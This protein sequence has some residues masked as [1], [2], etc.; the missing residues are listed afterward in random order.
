MNNLKSLE[1]LEGGICIRLVASQIKAISS[2]AA[3]DNFCTWPQSQLY[4]LNFSLL[5]SLKKH[6]DYMQLARS[7]GLQCH[8]QLH[9]KPA[10]REVGNT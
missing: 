4:I 9:P 5:L 6:L 7:R 3:F 2:P 8:Q 10:Q 1:K